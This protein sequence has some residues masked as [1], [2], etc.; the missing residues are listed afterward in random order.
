MT[1][2]VLQVRPDA[3]LAAGTRRSVAFVPLRQ[4][5]VRLTCR[6]PEVQIYNYCQQ[7]YPKTKVMAAG[8]RSKEGARQLFWGDVHST[9]THF[10]SLYAYISKDVAMSSDS[11]RLD[12]LPAPSRAALLTVVAAFLP[13]YAQPQAE[14]SLIRYL[15]ALS[16][17]E[18]SPYFANAYQSTRLRLQVELYSLTW[19]GGP[20]YVPP[21]VNQAAL[22]TLNALFPLGKTSRRLV[23]LAFRL[24]WRPTEWSKP[25]L[26]SINSAWHSVVR[27]LSGRLK[28]TWSAVQRLMPSRNQHIH[29]Q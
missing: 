14:G 20:R 15:L 26:L 1:V 13:Y 7:K 11:S 10:R 19:R 18:G 9:R 8:I 6:A 4:A 24:W 21:S 28:S 5:T 29:H 23:S 17:L 27:W 22:R 25:I 16:A 3:L 2:R 12:S